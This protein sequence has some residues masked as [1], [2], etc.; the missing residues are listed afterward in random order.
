MLKYFVWILLFFVWFFNVYA[1]DISSQD[2]VLTKT[3]WS[4]QKLDNLEVSEIIQNK[5]ILY[6]Y[7]YNWEVYFVTT[8]FSIYDWK[9][10]FVWDTWWFNV[11][12]RCSSGECKIIE[13]SNFLYF[14]WNISS[15]HFINILDKK[16][17]KYIFIPL[18]MYNDEYWQ[19]KYFSK[20][21]IDKSKSTN[22]YY[23]FV[24]SL[25]SNYRFNFVWDTFFLYFLE[26]YY[27]SSTIVINPNSFYE[28]K[29]NK[30]FSFYY[31]YIEDDLKWKYNWKYD[32]FKENVLPK[33]KFYYKYWDDYL[34]KIPH[35]FPIYSF[36]Y[37][38][39]DDWWKFFNSQYQLNSNIFTIYTN[40]LFF[41]N[42]YWIHYFYRN[43]DDIM[44][45]WTI[46]TWKVNWFIDKIFSSYKSC[47]IKYNKEEK[48]FKS[49]FVFSSTWWFWNNFWTF[50]FQKLKS[51]DS[52]YYSDYYYISTFFKK[53]NDWI[54]QKFQLYLWNDYI[55]DINNNQIFRIHVVKR[56]SWNFYVYYNSSTWVKMLSLSDTF[57]DFYVQSDDFIDKNKDWTDKEDLHF[58]KIKNQKQ[59]QTFLEKI[60]EE[61]K[62]LLW[63]IW[64][65]IQFFIAPFP[66]RQE[67]YSLDIPFIKLNDNL[68][69]DYT[70]Y[71]A[72]LPDFNKY[73]TVSV[74]WDTL[75][76]DNSL[77]K[78]FLSFLL[79]VFYIFIRFVLILFFFIPFILFYFVV[80]KLSSFIF[81]W[82][83]KPAEN[84]WTLFK[85]IYYW[86]LAIIFG[87]LW[88]FV[89]WLLIFI[90]MFNYWFNY[91]H[92]IFWYFLV[93][94]LD[95]DFFILFVNWFFT[96][97]T[98]WIIA[99][100]AYYVIKK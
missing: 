36:D 28:I 46:Q 70:K 3:D 16:N 23:N 91:I 100:F 97:L 1:E 7:K 33:I 10:E 17:L 86:Y 76:N 8:D 80:E 66:W 94:Y 11:K 38:V 63:D 57:K 2:Y 18:K 59:W 22:N 12:P 25:G 21:Y 95:F 78:K 32:S 92:T 75:K 14:I 96:F 43:N 20:I 89:L 29:D 13:N 30:Q 52:K 48:K 40:L 54:I 53:N 72:D 6:S 34:D 9:W 62:W 61:V 55:K 65:P 44:E 99:H 60:W 31:W 50:E 24:D 42:P 67:L 90:P 87:W 37:Y 83:W 73:K 15:I 49:S 35:W 45:K 58:E 39:N 47:H 74:L 82:I 81:W 69:I 77:W 64:K 84:S 85:F 41:C 27:Y 68:K 56:Q 93:N 5:Q 79:W 88:W 98:L 19:K 4:Y 26:D 51:N 71:R